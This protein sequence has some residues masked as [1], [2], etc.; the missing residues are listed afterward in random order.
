MAAEIV[1]VA[2][3]CQALCLILVLSSWLLQLEASHLCSREKEG[4]EGGVS[5]IGSLFILKVKLSQSSI[6]SCQKI[7]AYGSSTRAQAQGH[8]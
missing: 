8:P 3:Q 7:S 5:H 1:S 4:R 2:Q 6:S